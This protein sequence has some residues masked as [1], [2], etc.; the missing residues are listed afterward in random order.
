MQSKLRDLQPP[1]SDWQD[2]E[3]ITYEPGIRGSE[4]GEGTMFMSG[5]MKIDER[6]SYV[7]TWRSVRSLSSGRFHAQKRDAVALILRGLV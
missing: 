6:K 2:I 7:R 1:A 5:S 3:R 4:T